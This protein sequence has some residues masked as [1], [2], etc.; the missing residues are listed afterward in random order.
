M[1]SIIEQSSF[2]NGANATFVA[3][4]YAKFLEHPDSVDPSWRDFF[5]SLHGDARELLDE[6]RGASWA[7]RSTTVVG[8]GNGT[9]G[10]NGAGVRFNNSFGNSTNY[11]SFT[12]HN[13]NSRISGSG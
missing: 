13:T 2:L 1:G 11:K 12:P 6:I 5:G 8:H 10:G 9:N 4:I 7:P 3:E